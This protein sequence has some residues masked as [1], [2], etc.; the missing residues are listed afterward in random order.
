[1]EVL[2]SRVIDYDLGHSSLVGRSQSELIP[3]IMD[4]KTHNELVDARCQSTSGMPG[5]ET[6]AIM[7]LKSNTYEFIRV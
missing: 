6:I 1:L 7:N 3:R 5:V 4:W 2:C